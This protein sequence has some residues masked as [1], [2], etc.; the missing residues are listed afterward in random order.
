MALKLI[1]L[2]TGG[3][4]FCT[5]TQARATGGIYLEAGGKRLY[6]DP[7]P[8]AV[9]HAARLKVPLRRL[10]AVLVSHSH[11]D[12]YTDAEVVIE[13]MTTGATRRKGLLAGSVS[14]MKGSGGIGPVISKYHQSCVD[15]AVTVRPG[16]SFSVGSVKIK[17]LRTRH[18]D[19]TTTGFRF[20]A[21]KELAYVPDGSYF[22]GM[23]EDYKGTDVLV[24]NTMFPRQA[25]PAP[26]KAKKF[27]HM[28]TNM[29]RELIEKAGPKQ[30]IIQHFGMTMLRAGPAAEAAWLEKETGV[31]TTAAKDFQTFDFSAG[32][33]RGWV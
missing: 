15:R 3:G 14:V 32:S 18:S 25:P 9:V 4:R 13:A 17:A 20:S 24:I 26:D 31:R 12:H 19:H 33:L 30:V 10:D 23:E 6:I 2:G 22:K 27:L 28:N 8:G 11:P 16:G 7:G 1:F 21:D 5:T 29:A